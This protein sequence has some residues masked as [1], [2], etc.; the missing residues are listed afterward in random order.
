MVHSSIFIILILLAVAALI[1]FYTQ[2]KNTNI[3]GMS[4]EINQVYR[5]DTSINVD[6]S[7]PYSSP[8][9]S[10][11]DAYASAD[12]TQ[13]STVHQPLQDTRQKS[14]Q[15]PEELL[16]IMNDSTQWAGLPPT[17]Q[18]NLT[19]VNLLKSGYHSGINTIGSSLRNANLQLRSEPP[20]P[21]VYSGPWN[22][23]TITQDAVSR[24]VLEIGQGPL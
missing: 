16:P 8:P 6:G 1:F 10:T 14:I 13:S 7:T 5:D 3:S 12:G 18:G 24:P 23:S 22:M 2:D 17:G 19:N 21:Q 11:I 20:N 4:S 9:N 15:N